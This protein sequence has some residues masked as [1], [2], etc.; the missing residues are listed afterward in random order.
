MADI[1]FPT[2]CINNDPSSGVADS[3]AEAWTAALQKQVTNDFMPRWHAGATLVYIP[4]GQKPPAETWQIALLANSD[5]AGALGYHDLTPDGY[6]LGHIFCQT[7]AKYGLKSSVTLS[8]ELL[9]MLGDPEIN[10]CIQ[11]DNNT[12]AAYETADAVEDD[13]LGY[14]ID[15]ITVSNFVLPS[16]FA[17]ATEVDPEGYDFKKV[18]TGACPALATGG[19]MSIFDPSKGGWTQIGQARAEEGTRRLRRVKPRKEWEYSEYELA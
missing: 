12:F 14:D 15:G 2:I 18:L 10:L 9:E 8:H 1:T 3:D 16:Y 13:N 19:Y 11:L 5:Q 7:D 6:P 4:I 17:S